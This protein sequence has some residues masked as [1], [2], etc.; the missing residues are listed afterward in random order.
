MSELDKLYLLLAKRMK[1][2]TECKQ[3]EK[4]EE[5]ANTRD[6]AARFQCAMTSVARRCRYDSIAR[7]EKMQAG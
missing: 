6:A 4:A 5:E 2:H 3:K 7:A 1:Q